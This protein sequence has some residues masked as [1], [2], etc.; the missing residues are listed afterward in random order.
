MAKLRHT[1]GMYKI[2]YLTSGQYMKNSN[3]ED[4]TYVTYEEA[5]ESLKHDIETV[6]KN[7]GKWND[8][9]QDISTEGT[10][11]EFNIEEV[12]ERV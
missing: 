8:Y 1:N 11:I 12:N 10:E 6:T 2:L 9:N 7:N 4:L 3:N 5:Y